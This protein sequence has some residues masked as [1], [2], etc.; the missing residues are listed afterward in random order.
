VNDTR[1][2][3]TNA[4]LVSSA[5]FLGRNRGVLR[6]AFH[7]TDIR[8][9]WMPQ[10][11]AGRVKRRIGATL[12]DKRTN[13]VKRICPAASMIEWRSRAGI[14]RGLDPSTAHLLAGPRFV[15]PSI[16]D[17][18]VSSFRMDRCSSMPL[19]LTVRP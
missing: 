9:V 18:P 3:L 8:K 1:P 19:A 4:I 7:D 17:R 10:S 14:A 2:R 15:L 6:S 16:F 11:H 5:K 13:R 12:T